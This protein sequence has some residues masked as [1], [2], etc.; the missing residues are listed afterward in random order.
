MK[1]AP[2]K[3]PSSFRTPTSVCDISAVKLIDDPLDFAEIPK[4][5]LLKPAVVM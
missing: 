3:R 2:E 1:R 5:P 4:Q